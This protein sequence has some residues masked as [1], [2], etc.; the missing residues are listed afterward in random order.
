MATETI[1]LTNAAQNQTGFATFQ[2]RDPVGTAQGISV[3][4]NFYSYGG[5]GGDGIG[6]FI[7]DGNQS[8]IVRGGIGGSLGYA[9]YLGDSAGLQGGY[10]G[11]GFDSF[12][13]YSNPIEGRIGGRGPT[14]DSI[15]VRGSQANQ[16]QYLTGTGTLPQGLNV[17]TADPNAARRRAQVDLTSTGFLTVSVDFNNDGDFS[18]PG[19]VAIN[20]A[21]DTR[22]VAQGGNGALPTSVRFG[23]A[24]STGTATDIHQVDGFQVRTLATGQLIG[25]TFSTDLVLTGG[26]GNDISTGG[27]GNDTITGGGGNDNLAGGSGSDTITG[28]SGNDNIRGDDG[29]DILTGGGGRDTLTGGTGGDRFVFAGSTKANALRSST[30]RSLNRI[31][32]FNQ[33]EG[34]RFVLDFDNNLGTTSLPRGLFN[35]GQLRG[36][37]NRAIGLAYADKNRQQRGRQALRANEAV[38]FRLGNRTF[39]SVNDGNAAFSPRNDLVADITGISLKSGDARKGSL[40]VRDYFA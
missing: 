4:F 17:P 40:A 32:D 3:S 26:G 10:L 5:T 2:S 18:D 11:I 28:G 38:L 36:N 13:N 29:N 31:S 1:T 15:A 37:L 25:G 33:A 27:T 23:F 35:A 16:Y 24:A 12:G 6:F 14:P 8:S 30:V 22:P 21:I 9:P 19:E 34:D 20:E 39:L 7:I